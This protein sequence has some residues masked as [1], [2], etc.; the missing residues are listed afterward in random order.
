MNC[1]VTYREVPE[2]LS[3]TPGKVYKT[4]TL[5]QVS[6][7]HDDNGVTRP[8]EYLNSMLA[9]KFMYCESNSAL[10]R[11]RVTTE[12]DRVIEHVAGK[13]IR[14]EVRVEALEALEAKNAALLVQIQEMVRMVLEK[15]GNTEC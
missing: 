12:R 13:L 11:E 15:N 14:V 10:A 5:G 1:V 9:E 4:F 6:C 3:I 8:L 7:I 2:G